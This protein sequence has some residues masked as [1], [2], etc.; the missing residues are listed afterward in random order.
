MQA[1]QERIVSLIDVAEDAVGGFLATPDDVNDEIEQLLDALDPPL[2]RARSVIRG[3]AIAL[4]I[5]QQTVLERL[6]A[7]LRRVCRGSLFFVFSECAEVSMFC[8]KVDGV[9]L[10]FNVRGK[11]LSLRF[12]CTGPA[13]VLNLSPALQTSTT[14]PTASKYHV[15]LF[16]NN[17]VWHVSDRDCEAGAVAFYQTD[18]KRTHYFCCL[19][20]KVYYVLAGTI[21]RNNLV[22]QFTLYETSRPDF[23]PHRAKNI[24]RMTKG[25]S[26][27][28]MLSSSGE[29]HSHNSP[30]NCELRV[31]LVPEGEPKLEGEFVVI[32]QE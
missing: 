25:V 28:E 7:N 30:L 6:Q 15:V 8:T 9:N 12:E 24:A 19:L 31:R 21:K 1:L 23:T 17:K 2:A 26:V 27:H 29:C 14:P 5:R 4:G 13:E 22:L 11:P 10:K 20:N 16:V 18:E 3:V 32:S